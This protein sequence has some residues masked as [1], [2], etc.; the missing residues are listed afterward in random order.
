MTNLYNIFYLTKPNNL[1]KGVEKNCWE[2]KPVIRIFLLR[3]I[4]QTLINQT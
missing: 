2:A 1:P 4:A 3:L